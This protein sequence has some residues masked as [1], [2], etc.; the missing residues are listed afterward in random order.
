MK[1]KVGDRVRVKEGLKG[2]HS[3]GGISFME[4]M[5]E[6]C[7]KVFTV[8]EIT[9][10]DEVKLKGVTVWDFS[11]AMLEPAPFGKSALK[12]GMRVF[13]RNGED[14]VVMKDNAAGEDALVSLCGKM[15]NRLD[16]CH[17]DLTHV[18]YEDLDIVAVFEPEF[19]AYMLTEFDK[20]H[21]RPVWKREESPVEIT[22]AEIAELKGV[23]PERIRI[24]ED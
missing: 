12:T 10:F 4:D 19:E 24:K 11:E 21:F 20:E 2:E 1:F 13:L 14:R 16:Y 8:D 18:K 17:E 9:P 23:S 22:I 5:E 6:Y 15:W 7:G 3:Y